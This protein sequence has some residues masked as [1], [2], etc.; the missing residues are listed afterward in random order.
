MS[1]AQRTVNVLNINLFF[2]QVNQEVQDCISNINKELHRIESLIELDDIKEGISIGEEELNNSVIKLL[3]LL[4]FILINIH[5]RYQEQNYYHKYSS[6][7][8]RFLSL[9]LKIYNQYISKLG[10]KQRKTFE[11]F[12]NKKLYKKFTDLYPNI[13]N[14]DFVNNLLKKIK[15]FEFFEARSKFIK[16]KKFLIPHNSMYDNFDDFKKNQKKYLQELYSLDLNILDYY[17]CY[18]N[19]TYFDSNEVELYI[20]IKDLEKLNK[21]YNNDNKEYNNDLINNFLLTNFY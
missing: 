2:I 14:K 11:S 21:E 18:N 4:S 12:I 5:G 15:F 13:Q 7:I 17:D 20:L 19:Q 6:N 8:I 9:A 1:Y 10:E 16:H 3:E